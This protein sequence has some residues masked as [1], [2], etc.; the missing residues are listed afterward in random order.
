MKKIIVGSVM[1]MSAYIGAWLA[2]EKGFYLIGKGL[3][4]IVNK[5]EVIK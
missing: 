2:I 1:V 5:K 3:E 4:G